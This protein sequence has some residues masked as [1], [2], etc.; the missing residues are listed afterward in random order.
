ML[1]LTSMAKELLIIDE[2][3]TWRFRGLNYSAY[4][5]YTFEQTWPDTSCGFGG[6]AGQAFTSCNVYAFVPNCNSCMA[7]SDPLAKVI[8]YIG[9]R[10]AY[11]V[12]KSVYI[13]EDIAAKNI[14][15]VAGSHIYFPDE[16]C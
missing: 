9:S 14:M 11:A 5:L 13:M 15:S 2:D 3:I 12:P 16:P 1:K 4:D 7:I 10:F 6:V 8:V